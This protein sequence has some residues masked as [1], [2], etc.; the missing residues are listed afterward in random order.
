MPAALITFDQL[1][2][3]A[4]ITAANSAGVLPMV[5]QACAPSVFCTSG[6]RSA[7]TTSSRI[8]ATETLVAAT[9]DALRVWGAAGLA[10]GHPTER[11]LRDARLLIIGDGSS[12]MQRNLIARQMGL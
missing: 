4:R 8:F 11:A 9:S 2:C 10:P 5:S 1:S 3:S 7:R 12:Q 6:R